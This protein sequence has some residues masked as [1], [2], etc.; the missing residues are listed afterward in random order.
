MLSPSAPT[1]NPLT[2]LTIALC[3]IALSFGMAG[4]GWATGMVGGL[5][6][7]SVGLGVLR[8]VMYRMGVAIAPLALFLFPIHGFFHPGTTILLTVGRFTLTQEGVAYAYLILSRLAVLAAALLAFSLSTTPAEL[9]ATLTQQGVSPSLTYL[10]ISPFQL[11]PE[12]RAKAA[13]ILAAQQARGLETEGS[14]W[15]RGRALVPLVVP[16]VL[17][18]LVD[19]EERALALEARAFRAQGRKTSLVH[20]PDSPAQRGFRFGLLGLTV[21]VIGWSQWQFFVSKI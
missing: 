18:A 21:A 2:K 13:T 8:P 9:V 4:Y 14:L 11:I 5:L 3:A 19:V 1:L 15:R 12:I 6:L 16:L 7:W 10:V 20:I 17:G